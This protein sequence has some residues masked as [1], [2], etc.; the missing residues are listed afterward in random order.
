MNITHENL[1]LTI[2][3]DIFI[4][5][6]AKISIQNKFLNLFSLSKLISSNPMESNGFST[7]C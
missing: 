6:I 5:L 2:T 1:S 3:R 7:L 4:K